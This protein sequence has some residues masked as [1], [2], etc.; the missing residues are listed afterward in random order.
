MYRA[1]IIAN[2]SIQD[3]IVE[4]LENAIKDFYYTLIPLAHG[5]GRHKLKL[6]TVTWPEENFILITYIGKE[7]LDIVKD[8]IRKLK[9][10]FPNEGM[11]LF[12]IQG[13]E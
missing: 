10:R 4:S 5:S 9:E 11:K 3:N 6:G 1:E 7:S 12:I 2:C 13:H 8:E